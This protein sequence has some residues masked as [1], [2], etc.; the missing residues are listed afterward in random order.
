MQHLLSVLCQFSGQVRRVTKPPTTN[1]GPI[2]VFGH[3]DL[4]VRK[5]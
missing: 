2:T 1:A 3:L 4:P 5:E